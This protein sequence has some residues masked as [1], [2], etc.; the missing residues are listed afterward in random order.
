M[1]EQRCTNVLTVAKSV[2][3][4]ERTRGFTNHQNLV[5]TSALSS[6]RRSTTMPKLNEIQD[7]RNKRKQANEHPTPDADLLSEFWDLLIK[8]H[9]KDGVQPLS[10]HPGLWE[11]K[12]DD[13]WEIRANG[14][15]EPIEHVPPF[16][17]YV[18]FNGW[19]AGV[20]DPSGSCFAAGSLANLETF[21]AA[22]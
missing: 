19:P 8:L 18:K 3:A 15:K 10:L 4:M 9:E 5:L 12:I 17:I 2:T 7:E 11:R 22:L 13:K 1:G 16:S 6:L 20:I 14:H 21:N